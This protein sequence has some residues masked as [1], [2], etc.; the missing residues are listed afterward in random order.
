M[1]ESIV[2]LSEEEERK[3]GKRGRRGG[4]GGGGGGGE[5][6]EEERKRKKEKL[7][8]HKNTLGHD[9][10]LRK[11]IHAVFESSEHLMV[12]QCCPC[13]ESLWTLCYLWQKVLL[14]CR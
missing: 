1:A 2:Y 8:L 5:G 11:V 7:M 10:C 4:E 14:Q 6:G 12:C 3:R 9:M 13:I